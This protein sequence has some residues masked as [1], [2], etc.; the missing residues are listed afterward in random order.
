MTE[1]ELGQLLLLKTNA[2]GE[3]LLRL[4]QTPSR[5]GATAEAVRWLLAAGADPNVTN[6]SMDSPLANA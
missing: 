5:E 4:C 3:V 6:E 2:E 1:K